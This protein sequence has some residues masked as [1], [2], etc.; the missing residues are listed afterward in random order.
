[1]RG[2]RQAQQLRA[3]QQ[4]C[5][6]RLIAIDVEAQAIAFTHESNGRSRRVAV[7]VAVAF[8]M[9]FSGTISKFVEKHPTLKMLA[10]SFLILIGVTL[11]AEGLG[12]HISKGYIYFA[13]TFSVMVEIL[14]IKVV[15]RSPKP[16][17]LH[18]PYTEDEP[19]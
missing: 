5:R 4:S 9:F 16:V 18:Q 15:G 2:S 3:Q 10:L 1:L 19:A 11:I 13:M 6:G 7:V 12:Q 14:N 8:M 17:Q